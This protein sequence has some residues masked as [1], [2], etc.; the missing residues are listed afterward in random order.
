MTKGRRGGLFAAATV[1]SCAA[2]VAALAATTGTGNAA[3]TAAPSN[4]SP[5]TISGRPSRTSPERNQRPLEWHDTADVRLLVAP[6]RHGRRQLLGHQ[7][8]RGQGLHAQGR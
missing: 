1:V 5:P 7:G 2:I 6:L 8:Y 4:V 3:E